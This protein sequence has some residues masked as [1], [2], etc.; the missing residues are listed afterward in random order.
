[1]TAPI[2]NFSKE[3]IYKVIPRAIIK[4]IFNEFEL[5]LTQSIHGIYHWA[6]VI[7]NGRLI[8]E[9]NK[10]NLN[11]IIA[12]AF[13]HDC[14]RVYEESD[15][16]HGLRGAEFMIQ[17][18]NELGL[19]QEEIY[20]VFQACEGHTDILFHSDKDIS[21]CWDADRLDLM[22][23]GIYPNPDK[24]NN[25]AA[26]NAGLISYLSKNAFNHVEIGWANALIA[27]IQSFK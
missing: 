4:K 20:K 24:L 21:T 22:R 11:V 26:K 12:F 2:D 18:E 27:D 17:F 13:F 9:Q 16:E 8:A 14:K 3:N 10:A 5:N 23:C 6:R 7:Q 25:E 15:P 19:T 1:M